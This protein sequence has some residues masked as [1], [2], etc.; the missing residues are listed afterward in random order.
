[1]KLRS[2]PEVGILIRTH[3]AMTASN[4]RSIWYALKHRG[5][6]ILMGF[7][8]MLLINKNIDTLNG[9]D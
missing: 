6:Y 2:L 7:K 4:E 5:R 1:M 3:V 9:P 8:R